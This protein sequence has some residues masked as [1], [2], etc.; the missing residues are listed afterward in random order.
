MLL[1]LVEVKKMY[2]R[3][4]LAAY[5]LMVLNQYYIKDHLIYFVINNATTNNYI[6]ISILD[7]LFEKDRFSYNC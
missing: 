3:E 4:Q 2:T 1:A 7:Q 5:I 6:I